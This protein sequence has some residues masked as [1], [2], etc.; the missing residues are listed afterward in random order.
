MRRKRVE[1]D[2]VF[3]CCFNVLVRWV[4]LYSCVSDVRPNAKWWP[5][6][7]AGL[8]PYLVFGWLSSTRRVRSPT[9]TFSVLYHTATLNGFPVRVPLQPIRTRCRI[10]ADMFLFLTLVSLIILHNYL[11]SHIAIP[12][13]KF[14]KQVL[15]FPITNGSFTL[16][17]VAIGNCLR[18]FIT[19]PEL[20]TEASASPFL[21]FKI[22]CI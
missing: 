11:I 22:N 8:L 4:R 18:Y 21:M 16:F 14:I 19:K 17:T 1:T 5:Q 13:K 15:Y 6:H 20:I 12:T 10:A 7:S 2:L 9:N 3:Y